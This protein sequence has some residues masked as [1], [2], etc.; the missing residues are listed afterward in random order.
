M[1]RVLGNDLTLTVNGIAIQILVLFRL[2][3]STV[4]LANVPTD[5]YVVNG[6]PRLRF[7]TGRGR[8]A[9][10]G[11]SLRLFRSQLGFQIQ[12]PLSPER[13]EDPARF[14]FVHHHGA[15]GSCEGEQH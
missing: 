12:R 11:C 7:G 8:I 6:A 15:L 13:V 3:P 10:S 5:T 9:F 4:L 1:P 2:P 14:G